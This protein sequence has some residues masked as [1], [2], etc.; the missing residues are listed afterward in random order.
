MKSRFHSASFITSAL[1]GLGS[2]GAVQA[3]EVY[4]GIGLFG[5]QVGYAHAV[6]PNMTVRGDYMLLGNRSK[7]TNE[8]GTQYLANVKWSRTALVADWF[9]FETSTFRLTGGATFNNVA[10]DLTAGGTGT[11]VDINGKTYSLAANDTLNVKVKMPSTTPYLGLGWGHKQSSKGWGFHADL[12]VSIGQFKVTE[13]RTG[14]LAN[15]G[16]LGVT[17]AEVDAEMA[18][19]REGVAKVK[20]LPQATL[21]VSYRF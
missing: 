18:D 7:T 1:M 11:K 8:S 12:G 6:S 14:R 21:G 17:Q 9:P 16:A 13:T 2:I 19:I 4:G 5:V 10:V 15:G 3:Q 20:F